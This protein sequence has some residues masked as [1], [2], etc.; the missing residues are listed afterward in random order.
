MRQ[1]EKTAGLQSNLVRDLTWS[2]SGLSQGRR[3]T[4]SLSDDDASTPLIGCGCATRLMLRS[5]ESQR[6]VWTWTWLLASPP[7]LLAAS[8]VLLRA[9]RFRLC[10]V[11]LYVKEPN[12][13]RFPENSPSLLLSF[14]PFAPLLYFN[15]S[16]LRTSSSKL[17]QFHQTETPAAAWQANQSS[18]SP[19]SNFRGLLKR[20]PSSHCH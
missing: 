20:P 17:C 11:I 8:C 14:P 2:P 12:A 16:H 5:R 1:N 13:R 10:R 4:H 19:A 18:R 9:E 6:R 3:S 7:Q 15:E